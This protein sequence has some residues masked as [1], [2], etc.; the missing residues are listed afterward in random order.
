MK[1][2]TIG[3]V[4]PTPQAKLPTLRQWLKTVGEGKIAQAYMVTKVW[5]PNVYSNFTFE[6][7][8]F[9][10]RIDENHPLYSD[11]ISLVPEWCKEDMALAVAVD[12]E[13]DGSFE[14]KDLEEN[15]DW[16]ELGE[17]GYLIKV[18]DKRDNAKPTTG[19]KK[20]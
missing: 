2:L 14:F 5:K 16:Q 3:K 9:R 20:K 8:K 19:A 18:L 6:T 1:D 15:V 10:V 7:E 13:R 12:E 11:L 17:T 4:K